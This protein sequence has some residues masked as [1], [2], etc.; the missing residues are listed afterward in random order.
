MFAWFLV[1]VLLAAVLWAL[2]SD[3][4]SAERIQELIGW[5][6]DQTIL[7]ASF[8]VGP[9]SFRYYKFSSAESST[10]A[11]LVGHFTSAAEA[12]DRKDKGQPAEKESDNNVEV[13]VLTDSAFVIWQNGYSA[14]M[15]Y[16]SGRATE[17]TVRADIP[18]GPGIYY[19][20]FSNK[21]DPKT[22]KT[23]H[24]KVLLRYK[25]WS[26]NWFRRV[27]DWFGFGED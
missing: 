16:E 9:H 8:T 11:A 26:S 1:A 25:S 17:G 20:V 23:V 14:S 27:K 22:P 4:S 18:A 6:H 2:T 10:N 19:L 21:S 5:K 15:I 13:F 24:A 12:A 7:D 3:S